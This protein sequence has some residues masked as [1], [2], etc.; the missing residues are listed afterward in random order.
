MSWTVEDI[1]DQTGRTAVVTGGNGGL[2]LE[3]A[4]RLAQ[5]GAT[6]L[7]AC[8]NVGK[9]E[10]AA[11]GIRADAPGAVVEVGA[12]DLA[13]LSSVD[14]FADQFA[15]T[16]L[17]LDLLVNNAGLMAVD[18][19]RTVDGFETHFGVNHLGHFA[20]TERL[21]PM[22]ERTGG[23]RVATMS[24]MG[25][26]AGRMNFDD[27]MGDGH[28][29]RWGAYTQSK[30]ANLL[31]TLELQRRLADSRSATIAVAAHP[32][33]SRTDL[34]K[35]GTSLSNRGHGLRR[36]L[37]HAVG[38]ARRAS[39]APGRHG[40]RRAGRPV[41]RAALARLR[42]SRAGDAVAPGSQRRGRPAPV[43]RLGRADPACG[44]ATMTGRPLR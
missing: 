13:D 29:R 27:L 36:A 44:V 18:Q 1:P 22:L 42:P 41:L 5:H 32:G 20:L 2:G 21:R 28:Y 37:P 43:G 31:F 34:G 17:R 19:S 9:A 8:R 7:L 3:V 6:V 26:R 12:L 11:T 33:G 35:E 38:G 23:S 25:H 10:A 14:A 16:H 24:S 15:S 40:P 39:D 30:L 4:T